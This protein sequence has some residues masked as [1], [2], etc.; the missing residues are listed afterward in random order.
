VFFEI[1][2]ESFKF[3]IESYESIPWEAGRVPGFLDSAIGAFTDS[4]L[5]FNSIKT[6]CC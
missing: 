1:P 4:K 3:L 5:R 6:N 2:V